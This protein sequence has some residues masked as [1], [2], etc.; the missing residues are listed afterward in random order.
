MTFHRLKERMN[1]EGPFT[2]NLNFET[3]LTDE[4]E[5]KDGD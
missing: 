2:V 5:N 3:L 4:Q 1:Q